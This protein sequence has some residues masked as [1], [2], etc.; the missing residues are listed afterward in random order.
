M[1]EN[2]E[3]G[4]PQKE[5]MRAPDGMKLR[6]RRLEAPG[7]GKKSLFKTFQKRVEPLKRYV[8]NVRE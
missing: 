5:N 1:Q 4:A 2:Q 6:E 3:I 8:S 7:S